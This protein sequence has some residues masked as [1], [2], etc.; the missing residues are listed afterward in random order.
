MICLISYD[1]SRVYAR[2]GTS[3]VDLTF[4]RHSGCSM[5]AG[6]PILL[7]FGLNRQSPTDMHTYNCY[8]SHPT[9]ISVHRYSEMGLTRTGPLVL[10]KNVPVRSWIRN[11]HN[12]NKKNTGRDGTQ[13]TRRCWSSLTR[14]G[15]VLQTQENSPPCNDEIGFVE[16]STTLQQP[17]KLA[18]V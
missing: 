6:K 12:K 7:H 13:A 3:Q 8:G 1:M 9:Y 5:I 4:A 18:T 15:G 10:P 17:R 16:G 2:A 11:C 14:Y